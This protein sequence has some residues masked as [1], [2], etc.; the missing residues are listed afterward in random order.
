[1]KM[2]TRTSC[3]LIRGLN[4]L[5]LLG[6]ILGDLLAFVLICCQGFECRIEHLDHDAFIIFGSMTHFFSFSSYP[7]GSS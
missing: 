7:E 4:T 3:E 2:S 5:V 6:V 1:M